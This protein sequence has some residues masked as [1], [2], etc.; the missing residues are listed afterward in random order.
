MTSSLNDVWSALASANPQLADAL[1]KVETRAEGLLAEI[2]QQA[3]E[4]ADALHGLLSDSIDLGDVH[5]ALG[6]VVSALESLHP[7]TLQ[8]S[9]SST[10]QH[11][12]WETLFSETLGPIGESLAQL[13]DTV[14]ADVADFVDGLDG[15]APTPAEV[16]ALASDL[17]DALH[18][19]LAS[20]KHDLHP[21]TLV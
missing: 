4:R 19:F 8:A 18:T 5:D 16:K 1:D 13:H 2:Q 17:G 15:H 7:A 9:Q 12:T 3:Q 14:Q 21:D 11:V 20:L 6:Q 10:T